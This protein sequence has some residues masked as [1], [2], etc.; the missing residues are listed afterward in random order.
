MGDAIAIR[1]AGMAELVDARVSKTRSQ[2]EC[3]FDSDCPHQP[4][5]CDRRALDQ[6]SRRRDAVV[7]SLPR[8]AQTTRDKRK[9]GETI[10]DTV[11]SIKFNDIDENSG[12]PIEGL[13]TIRL[14]S[15]PQ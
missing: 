14:I 10:S 2:K 11:G 15:I 3:R 13:M 1:R 6:S 5:K 8:Y 9:A 4:R 7:L 12:R